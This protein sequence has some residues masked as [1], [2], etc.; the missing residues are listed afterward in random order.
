MKRPGLAAVLLLLANAFFV[1]VVDIVTIK[2]HRISGN[3]NP[4][5]AALAIGWLLLAALGFFYW[6]RL[7][8]WKR[9][10]RTDSVLFFVSIGVLGAALRLEHL[11]IAELL[12]AL[13]GGVGDPES[14]IYRFG[15]LNQYTNTFYY[16]GYLIAAVVAILSAIGSGTRWLAPRDRSAAK[17][18]NSAE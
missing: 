3:G 11:H 18:S 14:R 13:G 9:S 5:I 1:F 16:N 10:R 2:P 7:S 12:D 15:F 6:I 17:A 8:R 4:G